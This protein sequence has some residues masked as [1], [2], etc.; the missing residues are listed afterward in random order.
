MFWYV[1][2]QIRKAEEYVLKEQVNFD[3]FLFLSS[4]LLITHILYF[5]DFFL[6]SLIFNAL[7][8]IIITVVVIII[9]IMTTTTITAIIIIIIIIISVKWYM[10]SGV[11]GTSMS[12]FS[13]NQLFRPDLFTPGS[14]AQSVLQQHWLHVRIPVSVLEMYHEI[15][16]TFILPLSP[17]PLILDKSAGVGGGALHYSYLISP[18]KYDVG[19]HLS[20]ALLFV[21][22]HICMWIN[23]RNIST[24]W[25]KKAP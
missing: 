3:I 20:E 16:S 4:I 10:Y 5:C 23:K 9:I 19:T 25:L 24:F 13:N 22:H 8:I 15:I 17:I 21:S 7:N 1:R 14:L 11:S 6:S 12:I 2:E 18:Q